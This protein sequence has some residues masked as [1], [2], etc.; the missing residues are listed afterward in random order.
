MERKGYKNEAEYI[1]AVNGWRRSCDERGLSELQ[2]CKLNYNFLCYIFE[3]WMPWYKANWDYSLLEVNR[4]INVTI[5]SIKTPFC[6][7][8]FHFMLTFNP[9]I[10]HS[11]MSAAY[12]VLPRRFLQL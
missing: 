6:V 10:I 12:V 8:P 9:I 1:K 3:D 2:R 7:P 5:N 4:Y 11:G